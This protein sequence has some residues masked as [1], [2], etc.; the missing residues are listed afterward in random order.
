ML[1]I[2]PMHVYVRCEISCVDRRVSATPL[3]GGIHSPNPVS[4]HNSDDVLDI[5]FPTAPVFTTENTICLMNLKFSENKDLYTTQLY[6]IPQSLDVKDPPHGTIV[7]MN[8][9]DL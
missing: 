1:A 3:K 9:T 5:E 4:E 2:G 6:F 8:L 7:F